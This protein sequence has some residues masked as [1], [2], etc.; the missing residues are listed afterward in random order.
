MHGSPLG[1]EEIKLTKENLGLPADKDFYVSEEVSSYAIK[2]VAKGSDREIAWNALFEEYKKA[3]T[4]LATELEAIIEGKISEK[5]I[6]ALPK[7][8]VGKSMATRSASG[9][10]LTNIAPEITQLIGGSADLTPSNNTLPKGEESFS[11]KNPAGRY[12]RYGIREFGMGAIMN[13]LALHGG[14]LPYGGT[15]FVFSDYM[16]NAMR[17]AALMGLQVVYVLTHDS[18]GLGEDGPTHQPVEHL[19]SLQLMPNLSVIRPADASETA[20]AWKIALKNTNKPTAIVLTRQG[21]PIMSEEI[22]KN[23]EKGAYVVTE[24]ADYKV[25]LMASGSEVEITVNTKKILNGK[26]INVRVVSM[27][28]VDVFD[29]Q[30]DEY[31]TSILGDNSIPKVA[32]EAGSTMG[33]HKYIAGNGTIVGMDTFGASAPYKELYEKYGI[34]AENVADKA[35]GYK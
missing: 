8:E 9:E 12:V 17:M 22:T 18:I 29:L 30:S 34:T 14:V 27:P 5:A 2:E 20:V 13:G 11:P 24:D 28:S 1:A 7:F 15:F 31:K 19:A 3:N 25:I 35:L 26:N 23:A 16:R 21:L 32:V 4:D 33:W 10:V 6:A